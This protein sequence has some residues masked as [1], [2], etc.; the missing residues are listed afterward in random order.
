MQKQ[1]A[2]IAHQK[3]KKQKQKLE[4][5][6]R[7]TKKKQKKQTKLITRR[8]RAASS[9]SKSAVCNERKQTALPND[10][11][12]GNGIRN[13]M[14]KLQCPPLQLSFVAIHRRNAEQNNPMEIQRQWLN[15]HHSEERMGHEN[16][17]FG[18]DR[19]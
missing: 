19:F 3:Q 10:L 4:K 5:K 18:A 2:V 16:S 8:F 11:R 1:K 13:V 12:N 7:N 17:N 15:A 6:M 9:Q 14:N